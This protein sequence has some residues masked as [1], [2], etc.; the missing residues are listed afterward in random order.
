MGWFE[1]QANLP[2]KLRAQPG[3]SHN[4]PVRFWII[5]MMLVLVG[6]ST[7][8]LHWETKGEG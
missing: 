5:T 3:R 1:A 4:H 2:G 8:E 6:L 7:L